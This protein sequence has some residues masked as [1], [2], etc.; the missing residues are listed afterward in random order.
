MKL[1]YKIANGLMITLVLATVALALVLSHSSDCEAVPGP[2]AET[3][4]MKAIV[5]RCYGSPDVLEFTD[6][7]IPVPG[8]DEVLVKVHAASVNPLD[9]HF[10]RG[11]PYVIRLFSGLGAPDDPGVGVDFSGTVKVV[12]KDVTRYRVGD[13]VFGGANGAFAEYVLKKEDSH[14]F[15]PKP[16]NIS[17]E[18]AAAVPIAGLTALQ[19]VRDAGKL[20]AGEKVL[21]N[22][23]SGGVGTLA[24]QIA[25][26]IGAE[27]TGV[28][29]TRN[30]EM[31]RSIG[32]DHVIDYKANNYTQNGMQYDLIIDM[33]GNHSIS[34]NRKALKSEGR[35]VM[36]GGAKGNWIAPF[37]GSIN[38]KITALFVDQEIGTILSEFNN[39]DLKILGELMQ[40]GELDP[41]IGSRFA[42]AETAAAIRHSEQGHAQGKIII[43]M[44]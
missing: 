43:E 11:A 25:K 20:K 26:S 3:A 38:A 15:A 14:S 7:A 12:G 28:C 29:S 2:T 42:L 37:V 40:T 8:D 9:W 31:V 32:A 6:I 33:V 22:G 17:H 13:E 19:A 34:D 44:D 21:I 39:D 18:Q 41:V 24:V 23:A 27:V 1:R 36:V 30:L 35:M 5:G 4:T 10:M 16:D